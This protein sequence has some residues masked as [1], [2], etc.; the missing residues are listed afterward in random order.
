MIDNDFLMHAMAGDEVF[1]KLFD[2]VSILAIT[3]R[4]LDAGTLAR[5]VPGY[6]PGYYSEMLKHAPQSFFKFNSDLRRMPEA[7]R[8]AV[9]D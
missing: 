3:G 2:A 9:V 6:P 8:K 7:D 5:Q 1:V 4:S